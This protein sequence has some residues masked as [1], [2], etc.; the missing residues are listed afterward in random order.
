[1]M[2]KVTHNNEDLHDVVDALAEVVVEVLVTRSRESEHR[3]AETRRV[4]VS[5]TSTRTR[6]VSGS[7]AEL[8][9]KIYTCVF[10]LGLK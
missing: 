2:L 6:Q 8:K 5:V 3:G 10:C 4:S 9:C 7:D 1:M